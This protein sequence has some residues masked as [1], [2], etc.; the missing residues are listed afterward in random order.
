M[1]IYLYIFIPIITLLLLF[2]IF[3]FMKIKFHI[4][5]SNDVIFVKFGI[6]KVYDSTKNKNNKSKQ[7][8]K[9]EFGEDFITIKK[10]FYI[11]KGIITDKND[12]LILA[13]RYINKFIKI[14]NI[15]ISIDYGFDDA[16]ITG[17][18]NGIIWGIVSIATSFIYK[19]IDL[20]KYLNIAITPHYDHSQ[21]RYK[22]DFSGRVSLKN[23]IEFSKHI[24]RLINTI[25]RGK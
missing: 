8:K 20:R 14:K 7:V 4:Y 25:K 15:N 23:F 5:I 16:A 21:F 1:K 10:V 9:K 11:V 24:S 22:L 13:I 6:F 2:L 19:Y 3:Y 17:I 12:D 18:S